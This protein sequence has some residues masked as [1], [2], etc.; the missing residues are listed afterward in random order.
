MILPPFVQSPL[1]LSCPGFFHAFPGIDPAGRSSGEMT[2]DVFCIPPDSVSTLSQVHSAD[3]L[4]AEGRDAGLTRD[5]KREGDGLVSIGVGRGAAVFTADC[6][7]MLLVVPG[8]EICAAIHAGWRGLAAGIV[9]NAVDALVR[10][11]GESVRGGL[12][13]AVG[14]CA[15]GCCYE[16][17]D[18]VAD[19][20]R[21]LPGAS[22]A[23][24]TGRSSWKWMVDLQAVALAQLG[25]AGV[26]SSHAEAVGSCTICSR[27]FNS[28]RRD[29]AKAGRQASFVCRV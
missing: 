14:P 17:D 11:G 21:T 9:A 7:P 18:A 26:P 15:K 10:V 2:R 6:V 13:A 19:A 28:F 24:V 20:M 23:V 25:V 3:V 29:G 1:L 27:H 16:V 12:L 5:G 22:A 4:V 8:T